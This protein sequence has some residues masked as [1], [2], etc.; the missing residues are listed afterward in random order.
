MSDILAAAVRSP[1]NS[2]SWRKT[3]LSLAIWHAGV[4]SA[5][6]PEA[7]QIG[8]SMGEILKG[9]SEEFSN[10]RNELNGQRN[11]S[12]NQKATCSTNR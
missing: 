5:A 8:T 3:E 4:L 10:E 1:R 9:S 12:V 2:H 7:H 11:I 6:G